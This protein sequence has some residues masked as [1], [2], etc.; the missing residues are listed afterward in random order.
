MKNNG[1]GEG[2]SLEPEPRRQ[3][4]CGGC[5]QRVFEAPTNPK[6]LQAR[7]GVAGFPASI[8]AVSVANWR[9]IEK[10]VLLKRFEL[11]TSPLP[12]ECSTPEL[13]QHMQG[14]RG[15]RW[16]WRHICQSRKKLPVDHVARPRATPVDRSG[17]TLPQRSQPSKAQTTPLFCCAKMCS[18]PARCGVLRL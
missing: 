16:L 17:R 13:R 18:R 8:G 7:P 12:R 1:G 14:A 10:M 4:W 15:W 3:G 6:D 2:R 5:P 9:E 11:L